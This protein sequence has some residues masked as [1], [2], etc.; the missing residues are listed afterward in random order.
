MEESISGEQLFISLTIIAALV[1]FAMLLIM[2][3]TD[4]DNYRH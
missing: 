2:K 3:A 1:A 4:D